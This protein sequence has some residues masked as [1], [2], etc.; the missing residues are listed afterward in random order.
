M[1]RDLT[2]APMPYADS[3]AGERRRIAI[4]LYGTGR[5]HI[6]GGDL[7]VHGANASPSVWISA[8]DM[9][10][11]SKTFAH[12]F[13]HVIQFYSGAFAAGRP[14]GRS[15]KASQTG[16]ASAGGGARR[17]GFRITGNHL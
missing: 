15:G 12:E 4:Y 17:P 14:P 13:G 9:A 2:G 7:T 16:W 10:F 5:P 6:D 1:S 11:G 8:Q 3:P